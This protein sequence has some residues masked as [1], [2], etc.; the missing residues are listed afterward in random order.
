MSKRLQVVIPDDEFTRVH[1]A[2]R[3]QGITTSEWVR[4]V[5][6]QAE[7]AVSTGDPDAKLAAIRAAA[8]HAFPTGDIDEMLGDI[9][10]GYA[11]EAE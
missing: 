3:M 11:E 8:R 7:R 9:E 2:A 6:R 10:R 5:L 4:Q 1:E